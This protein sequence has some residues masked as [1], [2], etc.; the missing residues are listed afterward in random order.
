[1]AQKV[2]SRQAAKKAKSLPAT[3]TSSNGPLGPDHSKSGGIRNT[4]G[5][6]PG[7]W[8]EILAS[9]QPAFDASHQAEELLEQ[10]RYD[11]AYAAITQFRQGRRDDIT[12]DATVYCALL[13][14]HYAEAYELLVP[15]V[16]RQGDNSPQ[17]WLALSFASAELGHVYPGQA[18]F[19]RAQVAKGLSNEVLEVRDDKLV[20]RLVAGA[21]PKTTAILSC[22]GLG[23]AFGMS[24]FLEN[25]LWLDPQ[26]VMAAHALLFRYTRKERP[27]DVRRIAT[28]MVETLQ[29]NDPQ[30]AEFARTLAAAK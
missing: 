16:R 18:D 1:M 9:W 6:L 29:P 13:T 22:L 19:C 26:N 27:Y 2:L 21:D 15:M 4:G 3:A 28:I 12:D 17:Y 24:P 30:R 7:N 5:T 8:E 11:D 10:G 23:F 14:G 25:A 20:G